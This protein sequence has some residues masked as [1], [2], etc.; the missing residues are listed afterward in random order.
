[1]SNFHSDTRGR[2]WSLIWAHLFSCAVRREEHC[3]QI[4]LACV[5][6]ARNVWDTLGLPPLVCMCDFPVYTAQAPDCS[7]VELSK[8]GPGLGALPSPK[9]LRFKFSGTSQRHRLDWAC[10]LCPSQVRAAQVTRCLVSTFSQFGGLPWSQKLGFLGA[11]PEHHLRC[12]V[13]LLWRPG[14]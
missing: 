8:V 11:Q 2:R 10:V 4:S 6:S 9:L 14:L 12:A 13:C 1:M 5:R 7:A 3:K